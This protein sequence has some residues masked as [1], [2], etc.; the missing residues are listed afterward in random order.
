VTVAA[1]VHRGGGL[2]REIVY[3]PARFRVRAAF[4]TDASLELMFE[5][6]RVSVDAAR[7]L[8]DVSATDLDAEGTPQQKTQEN[9]ATT[10][11]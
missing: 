9:V 7:I 10:G 3:L 4:E 8:R 2:G 5:R 6:G 11:A 1:R